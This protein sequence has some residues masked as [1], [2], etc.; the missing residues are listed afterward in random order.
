VFADWITTVSP[1]YAREIQTP[2]LG[3]GLDGLLRARGGRLVG[4]LNGAD[5]D[6]W[7]P[8]RD[9]LLA[10]HYS[11]E[12][13]AGKRTC[14]ADLQRA[15]GLPPRRE[16]PL[17]GAVSRL[18]HQKGFDLAADVLER[19]L[20]ARE[21]QLAI[22]G[23][24][25]PPIE[26]RLGELQARW[27]GR[28]ALRLGHDEPLAHRIYAGCDLYLMP[29][30]YEPCG[31]SQ[32]YAL[33]YGAPPIVRATGGLDDT[34]VDDDPRSGTG[35]GFKFGPLTAGALETALKRALAAYASDDFHH[36]VARAM[37]QDFS[38]RRSA[39]SYLDLY[40]RA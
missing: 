1:T 21:V 6:L 31:L 25:D 30:R 28:V 12:D 17:V 40:R 9:A 35:T 27:P 32:L 16:V 4:I 23:A 18:S 11:I 29:S 22:L 3:C 37:R 10:A 26:K 13:L 34:V 33:R 2:E 19:L 20:D 8:E 14:K 38:W 24:G 5:Y 7:S 36:L 15:L 39:Q